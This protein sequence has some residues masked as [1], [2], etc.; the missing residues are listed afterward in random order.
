VPEKLQ[1]CDPVPLNPPHQTLASPCLD[2]VLA[3]QS[4]WRP[5]PRLFSSTREHG[6]PL[7][8]CRPSCGCRFL[9]RRAPRSFAS[10]C[11]GLLVG[12]FH[13]CPHVRFVLCAGSHP[14]TQTLAVVREPFAS[15]DQPLRPLNQLVRRLGPDA[16]AVTT[17]AAQPS[18]RAV[19]DTYTKQGD[20]RWESLG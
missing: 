7:L 20:G 15:F 19:V 8:A 5:A 13:S 12:A 14:S 1:T 18:T 6:V 16:V 11:G 2:Q 17:D 3:Q 9:V 4:P 10:P